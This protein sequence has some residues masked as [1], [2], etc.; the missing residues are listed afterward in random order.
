M[1]TF[2]RAANQI[3]SLL[4]EKKHV[5]VAKMNIRQE[6]TKMMHRYSLSS[7]NMLFVEIKLI[8]SIIDQKL[9]LLTGFLYCLQLYNKKNITRRFEDMNFIFPW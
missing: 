1:A 7:N 5:F 9:I 6:N 4:R 2:V 3:S 8:F